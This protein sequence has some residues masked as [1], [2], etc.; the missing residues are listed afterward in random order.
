MFGEAVFVIVIEKE[1]PDYEQEHEK[2]TGFRPNFGRVMY[3]SGLA[4]EQSNVF[5]FRHY[6]CIMPLPEQGIAPALSAGP[7]IHRVR[8]AGFYFSPLF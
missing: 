5:S 2:N 7:V 8:R 1:E 6:L 4:G 3:H